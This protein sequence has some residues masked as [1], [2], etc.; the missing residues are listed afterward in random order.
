MS[1]STEQ[2]VDEAHVL[3]SLAGGVFVGR[4][5]EMGQLKAAL[6]D[7]LSGR[8][9]IVTLVG[10]PG[11]GKTRTAQELATY[12]GLRGCQVLWGRSYEEQGVP[13]Y[14]PWVQAIR[15]YVRDRDPQELSSVMGAGAADIAEIVSDVKTQ[16]P[17]L[18]PPPRLDSPEQARFRLFDSITTFLKTASQRQPLVLMLDDLHWSDKPSLML[19]QFIVRELANTRL[20]I[21]GTYRDVE[22]NRQHPLAETLAELI[23]DR[24]FERVLLRGLT[25]QDVSRFIDEAVQVVCH[26]T[27]RLLGGVQ[28]TVTVGV[29]SVA[30]TDTAAG[31][32][33]R[34]QQYRHDGYIRVVGHTEGGAAGPDVNDVRADACVGDVE[35]ETGG[36][37][38]ARQVAAGKER[39]QMNACTIAISQCFLRT[40]DEG[41]EL[42]SRI[43]HLFNHPRASLLTRMRLAFPLVALSFARAHS[44]SAVH[45][46]DWPET[47]DLPRAHLCLAARPSSR[48]ARFARCHST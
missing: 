26:V 45:V 3:D 43:L 9:R 19:L 8:G 25:N 39:G 24:Q 20:L 28:H 30:V 23:R 38:T 15:S 33:V 2:P 32:V 34:R 12:A 31:Q 18:Q 1:T 35:P 41:F 14:W 44:S 46:L 13:P 17:G 37:A 22:L 42:I 16:L 7:A 10:E 48:S 40:V 27:H 21:I 4:Q 47:V 36:H 6:E 5:S 11:I 29:V